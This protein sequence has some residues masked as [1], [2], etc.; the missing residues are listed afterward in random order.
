[1]LQW[2]RKIVGTAASPV[3]NPIKKET[4]SIMQ[5]LFLNFV[6]GAAHALL[7]NLAALLL[8][9]ATSFHPALSSSVDM[10]IWAVVVMALTGLSHVLEGLGK[11]L[12][13][14]G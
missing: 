2:L 4:S 1:M 10:Q 3:M 5:T 8:F 9:A 7:A 6:R 12:D 13:K 11:K 14:N